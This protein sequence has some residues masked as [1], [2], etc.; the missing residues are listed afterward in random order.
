MRKTIVLFTII[1]SFN[2]CNFSFCEDI[3]DRFKGETKLV[4]KVY[5]NGWPAGSV[6]WVYLGRKDVAGIEVEVIGVN[7]DTKILNFLDLR[8]KE[9][10]FLDVATHLPIRVERDL[11]VFGKSEVIEELYNQEEGE[12]KIIK[13]NA[14][15]EEKIIYQEAPI[16]NILALLYFFPQDIKLN[17]GEWL[18]FNLPTRKVKMKVVSLREIVIRGE[19]KKAVFLLGRGGKRFNLWL[20]EKTRSLLRLEFILPIGKVTILKE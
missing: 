16:H 11:I 18:K 2:L 20:D 14:T 15:R 5:F 3:K 12:V 10:A 9:K 17:I 13:T 19:T 1:F 8:S 6:E 7:S 4:Y